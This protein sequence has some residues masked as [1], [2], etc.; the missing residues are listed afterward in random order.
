M[1]LTPNFLMTQSQSSVIKFSSFIFFYFSIS[2]DS[3]NPGTEAVSVKLREEGSVFPN[4]F[5][6][7][8]EG[9]NAFVPQL[10]HNTKSIFCH[11]VQFFY[12]FFN[13]K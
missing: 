13:L 3:K 8:G 7:E 12:F 1:L 10:F 11:Q 5:T 4:I 2:S 6:R 9:T